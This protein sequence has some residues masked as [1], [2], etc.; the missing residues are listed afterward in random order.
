MLIDS[1][2]ESNEL[3]S[4]ERPTLNDTEDMINVDMNSFGITSASSKNPVLKTV[5][6]GPCVCD[7][8]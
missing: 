2:L 8:I 7:I 4:V 6:L 5:G 1:S 3:Q